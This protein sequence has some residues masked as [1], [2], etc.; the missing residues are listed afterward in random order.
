MFG[1]MIATMLLLALCHLT[2]FA[3]DH[4][5]E[6]VAYK[7]DQD[8]DALLGEQCAVYH[9]FVQ[10]L[11]DAKFGG[12]RRSLKSWKE[13]AKRKSSCVDF[14]AEN[15]KYN[16]MYCFKWT[17]KYTDCDRRRRELKSDRRMLEDK[18]VDDENSDKNICLELQHTMLSAFLDAF[19]YK[20]ISDECIIYYVSNWRTKCFKLLSD[21]EE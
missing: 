2:A 6:V 7:E 3:W 21:D 13:K 17:N 10:S 1:H 15:F 11:I 20:F 19:D 4:D 14:C 8:Q 18:E 5:Y 12:D 9:N 16:R